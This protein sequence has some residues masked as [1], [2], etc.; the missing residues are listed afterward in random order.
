MEITFLCLRMKAS[1]SITC[2]D[3]VVNQNK[4][5]KIVQPFD[6]NEFGIIFYVHST[7]RGT[8][9]RPRTRIIYTPSGMGSD[10]QTRAIQRS[11][12]ES[13][14]NN[15]RKSLCP[16]YFLYIFSISLGNINIF[17]VKMAELQ[18]FQLHGTSLW[19]KWT[20]QLAHA[21][22]HLASCQCIW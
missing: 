5:V 17:M 7:W 12:M 19:C 1:N 18:L 22:C 9:H 11:K 3:F 20:K 10:V 6:W 14:T 4:L 2:S 21:Y 16:I 15:D 13:K 8:L